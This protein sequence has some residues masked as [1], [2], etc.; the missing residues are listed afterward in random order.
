MRYSVSDTAEWGDYVTGPTIVTDDTRAAM[1]QAL[2]NIQDG[3]FA[4]DWMTEARGG[5]GQLLA[6]RKAERDHE[7]E[8]VGAELRDMMPFL[9]PKKPA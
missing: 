4:R 2:A 8:Q 9:T 1:Q 6:R 7:I 5:A 3:S